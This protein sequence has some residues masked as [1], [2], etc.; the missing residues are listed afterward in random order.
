MF[1]LF[2]QNSLFF[3]NNASKKTSQVNTKKY[4]R[5]SNVCYVKNL[6]CLSCSTHFDCDATLGLIGSLLNERVH[7]MKN[8]IIRR[9]ET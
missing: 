2:Q 1:F 7:G 9:V 8:I 3:A 6:K 5:R 4:R